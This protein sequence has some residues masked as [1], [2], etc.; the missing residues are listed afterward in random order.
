MN[1]DLFLFSSFENRLW[2]YSDQ[3]LI[4]DLILLASKVLI[5]EKYLKLLKIG[6]NTSPIISIVLVAGGFKHGLE[7][8]RGNL[9]FLV[10]VRRNTVDVFLHGPGQPQ[11]EVTKGLSIGRDVA[12]EILLV[13]DLGHTEILW[14]IRV[15]DLIFCH[16]LN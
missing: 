5:H 10:A 4:G 9:S 6:K 11:V 15:F 1:V 2:L 12:V 13:N 16:L 3:N 8:S 14:Q 7:P